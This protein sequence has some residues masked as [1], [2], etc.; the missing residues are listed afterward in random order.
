M[1]T[2][3]KSKPKQKHLGFKLR[4]NI[5]IATLS[6]YKLGGKADYVAEPKTKD[7]AITVL[8][9]IEEQKLPFMIW[10][11]GT[12]I[13]PSDEE[14]KGVILHPKFEELSVSKNIITVGAGVLVADLLKFTIKKKLSGLEW[15][16][17]LPGT[18]G[19]AV[20]GNAGCFGGEIK[21]NL[22][23]VTSINIKTKKVET[24][25]KKN[26]Q[27]D[28]RQSYFKKREN[29]DLIVSARFKMKPGKEAD[30]KRSIKEKV[31]YRNDRHPLDYPS[32]GSMFKNVPWK[33]VPSKYQTQLQEVVKQDPFPVVPTA[34]LLSECKLKG[35]T[36]GGAQISEKH[37]NFIINKNHATAHDVKSLLFMMKRAVQKSFGIKIEEEVIILS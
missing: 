36:F 37:P 20:R 15:A 17:G 14:Y 32:I 16:G 23:S 4:K 8:N 6:N 21:D 11:G 3:I 18:V 19:G 35:K 28:Y 1:K 27:F 5:P 26:C 9:W 7:E 29:K 12:N 24:R 33:M 22:V 10:G 30:I 13:L 2:N 34:Y 31:D 25:S